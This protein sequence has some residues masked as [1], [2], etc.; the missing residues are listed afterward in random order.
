MKKKSTTSSR[1][2]RRTGAAIAATVLALPAVGLT[3]EALAQKP[4]EPITR[5][6][7]IEHKTA[8]KLG[9]KLDKH[10]G[11]ALTIV[12]LDAGSVVYRNARNEV[13]KLDP[14][15]GDMIFL[16]AGAYKS[17][18]VKFHKDLKF[19]KESA[20]IILIGT[21]AKGNVLHK[22]SRGETFYLDAAT[23]DMVFV[24]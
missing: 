18:G 22:N 13:F 17:I 6:S 15:T 20:A 14:A 3:Q 23:G 1:A 7:T 21:D 10:K 8:L 19:S 4:S 2:A 9:I 12:G 16:K 11:E 5:P 24:Q